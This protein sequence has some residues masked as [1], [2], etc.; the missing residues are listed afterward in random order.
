MKSIILFF[1][2]VTL[3]SCSSKETPDMRGTYLMVSQTLNDGTKDT[4]LTDL[5]QLKIYTDSFFMYTQV[6]PEDSNSAFG[7]GSYTPVEGGVTEDVIYS[8][9][10]TTVGTPKKYEVS[11]D[12]YHEGYK[13]IIPEI[14][15]DSV[16]NKLTEEYQDVSTDAK[17]PLDGLWKET[18]S[19][20]ITGTDSV[21]NNRT[22]YKT[23]YRGYFMFGQS[24]NDTA[25]ASG[26][27]V[28]IGFGT[29]EWKSDTQ[30][31]EI[32]LNSTYSILVGTP[33]NVAIEMDGTDKY[34]QTLKNA[35]G[36][37][38]VEYYERLKK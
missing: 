6:N 25:S 5:K 35:D 17:T 13:Q 26:I 18:K 1:L 4:R 34:K 7:V 38:G 20:V 2:I 24:I 29:F 33:F 23:Y 27:R 22:Q 8:A 37:T 30:I 15:I 21:L 16:Q 11:I 32:D 19:Y 9:S 3:Y 36:S 31:V 14:M 12:K 10:G 28:G